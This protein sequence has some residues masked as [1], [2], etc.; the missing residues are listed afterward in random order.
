MAW[1]FTAAMVAIS[2]SIRARGDALDAAAVVD[3]GVGRR[4]QG[5]DA[6]ALL[7]RLQVAAGGEGG[8]GAG[9]D[10][11][12]DLRVGVGARTPVDQGLAVV[13]LGDGVAR[14]SGR[15][16]VSVDHPAAFS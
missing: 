13:V 4:G 3:A 5:P 11:H 2:T 10:Q 9:Q 12:G 1:P 14:L 6:V 15:F 8:A 7:H 16:R